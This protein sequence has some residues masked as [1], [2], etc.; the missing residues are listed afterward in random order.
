LLPCG[1][2]ADEAL[3]VVDS[4][5]QTLAAEYADLDL[6]HVE[7]T[8]MLG[9]VVELQATQNSSGFGGRE[10][11]IEGTCRV[12]RQVV[13]YDPDARG[14]GIMDIDKFA[15]AL[16]VVFSR[17]PLGDLDPAPGTM[18]VD[19]DKEIDGAVAAVLVIVTFELTRPGRDRLAHLADQL[20]WAFIEADHRPRGIGRFGIEVEHVFHAGD[21]FAVDPGNAPHILAPWLETVFGQPPA[22]RLARQALV[23]GESYLKR[24]WFDTCVFRTD[25]IEA[26]A[27]MVGTDRLMMGSDFPF[28]MGD[29]DPVGLV[30][31]ARLSEADREKIT[32]GNASRLFKISKVGV[33]AR[34][35]VGLTVENSRPSG[36]PRSPF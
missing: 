33:D 31:R 20:D 13:L 14:I 21:I 18:H 10:C 32:F 16:G 9:G 17:P 23:P 36:R 2:F 28:D 26:L 29:D 1:D 34:H 8:G 3:G 4:A 19:A 7:P 30:N 22:H 5:I 6:D 24:L 25:L 12:G 11:L 35:G 15:H 27:A